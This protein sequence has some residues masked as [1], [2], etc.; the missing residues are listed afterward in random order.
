MRALG[1]RRRSARTSTLAASQR[2]HSTPRP[3]PRQSRA[4]V[5]PA[6]R[7]CQQLCLALPAG[8]VSRIRHAAG[9]DSKERAVS[10]GAEPL[11]S[12]NGKLSLRGVRE[13]EAHGRRKHS[14]THLPCS[15][16]DSEPR[17]RRISL[18]PSPH[19][20]TSEVSRF[21]PPLGVPQREYL[22]VTLNRQ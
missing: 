20:L 22:G 17:L 3:L 8:S 4:V 9:N 13:T 5:R 1:F 16:T 21:F 6:P 2:A 15:I 18:F 7:R 14:H 12:P 19:S 10:G 11:T